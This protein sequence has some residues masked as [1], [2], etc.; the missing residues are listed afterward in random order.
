MQTL[1]PFFT[2]CLTV[3]ASAR[4]GDIVTSFGHDG[5]LCRR[6]CLTS[7]GLEFYNALVSERDG[8]NLTSFFPRVQATGGRSPWQKIMDYF[9]SIFGVCVLD[10]AIEMMVRVLIKE[11]TNA[12]VLLVRFVLEHKKKEVAS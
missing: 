5:Q 7:H 11:T 2:S 3:F 6:V 12:A 4:E 9:A 8:R 1:L 10:A